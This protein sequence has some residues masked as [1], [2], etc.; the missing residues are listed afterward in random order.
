[1]KPACGA[2]V[3]L[4]AM[5]PLVTTRDSWPAVK[6]G[7]VVYVWAQITSPRRALPKSEGLKRRLISGL[8]WLNPHRD[9]AICCLAFLPGAPIPGLLLCN[10]QQLLP[11]AF[12]NAF[13]RHGQ[14][15]RPRPRVGSVHCTGRQ[16]SARPVLAR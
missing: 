8:G 13:T 6:D 4:A 2:P 12:P 1:M 14:R 16:R 15:T 10:G 3:W 7:T 5:R 9:I 11:A